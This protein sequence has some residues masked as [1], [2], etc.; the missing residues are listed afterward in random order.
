[1]PGIAVHVHDA[2]IAGVGILKP[3]VLGLYPL[4]DLRGG[5]DLA[6]GELIRYFA[7]AAWYP[8]ALLPSQGVQWV[9]VDDHNASATLTDGTLSVTMR[10]T[11]DNAGLME[12]ARFEARGATV[13]GQTVHIPWEGRW[14]DYQERGGMRMPITGEAAWLHPQAR[15]PYWHGSVTS[16]KHEFST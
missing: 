4:A 1:M 12:A 6:Q 13:D 14:S 7:E 2:Y 16:L 11:F 5:G 15:K 3:A 10:V 9:A 8:T